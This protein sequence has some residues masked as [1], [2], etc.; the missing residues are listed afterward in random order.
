MPEVPISQLFD[1]LGLARPHAVMQSPSRASGSPVARIRALCHFSGPLF[2]IIAYS[3]GGH[4]SP[5]PPSR[6]CRTSRPDGTSV[7]NFLCRSASTRRCFWESALAGGAG[8]GARKA[9]LVLVAGVVLEVCRGEVKNQPPARIDGPKNCRRGK[10]GG[11][12]GLSSDLASLGVL[13]E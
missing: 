10:S 9:V 2:A 3:V 8:R 1:P 7:S 13:R 6:C 12:R 4:A 11:N 5:H